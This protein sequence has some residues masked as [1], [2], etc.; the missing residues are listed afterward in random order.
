MKTEKQAWPL[1]QLFL[2]AIVLTLS[3]CGSSVERESISDKDNDSVAD[4]NDQCPLTA[5]AS[6]VD[7]AGCSLFKGN[8]E[9]VEFAPGDHRLNENSR[10]SLAGLVELLNQ[11]PQV[12]IQL[13][14]HTDNRG[15]ARENLALSKRR[16]MSVVKYLV[17]NGVEGERLKPYGFGESRPVMS[18][19]TVAGRA[20]NRR[21]E[22]SVVTQ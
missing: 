10:T 18:N 8:I 22:M 15:S 3:A 9:A 2:A 6:P 1:R 19:A 20:Q 21:I 11:H 13:G 5:P 14:G 12:V 16:V 17:A 7:N 4:A